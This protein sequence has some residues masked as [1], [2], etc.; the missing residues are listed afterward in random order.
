MTHQSAITAEDVQAVKR[1]IAKQ[2]RTATPENVR[3]RLVA[4]GV[5]LADDKSPAERRKAIALK[6]GPKRSK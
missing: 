3:A 6:S 5:L 2:V 4:S 1:H